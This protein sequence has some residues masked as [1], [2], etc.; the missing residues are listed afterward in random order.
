MGTLL[1]LHAMI[2]WRLSGPDIRPETLTHRWEV[3]ADGVTL[4]VA[5]Q[6]ADGG[7]TTHVWR[8]WYDAA[9]ERYRYTMAAD[10]WI[11]RQADIEFVNFYPARTLHSDPAQRR[12]TH[13]VWR[14]ETGAWCSMPH[15][16]ALTLGFTVAGTRKYL[17]A[18]GAEF[19]YVTDPQCN[20]FCRYN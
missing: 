7:H 5:G 8:V 10:L 6:Y 13:T 20:P 18:Q 16:S 19:G 4:T 1:N 17:P 14:D 11:T 9:L 12:F 3:T 2:H 15:A